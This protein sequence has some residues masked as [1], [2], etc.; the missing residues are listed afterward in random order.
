MKS[1]KKFVV[2]LDDFTV[3]TALTNLL[4]IKEH[5]PNFKVTAFTIPMNISVAKGEMPLEKYKEWAAIV[6]QYDWIEIAIHGFSH[7]Q[8][9]CKNIDRETAELMLTASEKMLKNELGLDYVKVF[10]APYWLA[11]K[12][13]Y[14]A[15]ANRGYLVAIDRNQL[16]PDIEGL[17][18]YVYNWSID[19]KRLPEGEWIKGHGHFYGTN[20]DIEFCMANMFDKF[21]TDSKFFTI[22]EYAEAIRHD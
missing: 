12:E 14:E 18:T 3:G 19:E 6:K 15:L 8:D 16:P 21:D 17:Q 1:P 2:E 5:F 20:N 7:M 4:K 10:K 9:E 11:S 13:M 22:T